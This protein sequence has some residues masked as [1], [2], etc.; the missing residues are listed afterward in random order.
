L[1]SLGA[2]V[3]SSQLRFWKSLKVDSPSSTPVDPI[4]SAAA[5]KSASISLSLAIRR[6]SCAVM[7]SIR[8]SPSFCTFYRQTRQPMTCA[9]SSISLH[10]FS[11][12]P[13]LL[14]ELLRQGHLF[15][16][17]CCST[18]RCRFRLLILRRIPVVLMSRQPT[19][20][21]CDK[22]DDLLLLFILISP[23]CPSYR[24]GRGCS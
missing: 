9:S 2:Y 16:R 5:A 23:S 11:P 13:L 10:L 18:R 7:V 12:Q 1:Q 8:S 22:G 17:W 24:S 4:R 15:L 19:I 21:E 20:K 6:L 14:R 3:L